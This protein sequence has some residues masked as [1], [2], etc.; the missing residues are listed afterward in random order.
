LLF[1]WLFASRTSGPSQ[2]ADEENE[3]VPGLST[4]VPKLLP[5]RSVAGPCESTNVIS[6]ARSVCAVAETGLFAPQY[7][8][9]DVH[10][11]GKPVQVPGTALDEPMLP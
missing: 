1:G 6:A 7:T 3:Y 2:N 5:L 8:V 4:S 9:P 10:G 11:V